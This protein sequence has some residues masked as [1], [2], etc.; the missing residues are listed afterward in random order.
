[1]WYRKGLILSVSILILFIGV[2]VLDRLGAREEK[3][4]KMETGLLWQYCQSTFFIS[5]PRPLLL[6][7]GT[8]LRYCAHLNWAG[9]TDWWLPNRAELLSLVNRNQ[10]V[11]AVDVLLRKVT[12]DNVYWSSN[13]NRQFPDQAYYVSFFSGNSYANSKYVQGYVRCVRR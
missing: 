13:T 2:G 12:K 9:Y 5:C 11:P 4:Y 8:A 10:R 6:D 7:W 3:I 1:M